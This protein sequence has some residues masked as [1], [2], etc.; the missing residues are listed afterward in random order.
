MKDTL[1]LPL[2]IGTALVVTALW[3]FNFVVIAVGVREIPPLLLA[4]LRFVL[5]AVPAIFF[6]RRPKVGWRLLVAYGLFL[7]VG[8]FGCL[9]QVIYDHLEEFEAYRYSLTALAE[10]VRPVF[11][12]ARQA[13]E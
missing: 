12:N 1:P 10:E 6:V 13:A 11:A 9:L 7:G 3:G 2:L 4:C 5:A 8:Q